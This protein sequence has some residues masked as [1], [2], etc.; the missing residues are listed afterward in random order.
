MYISL[1]ARLRNTSPISSITSISLHFCH[2]V[3]AKEDKTWVLTSN[4][5]NG[6]LKIGTGKGTRKVTVEYFGLHVR[7]HTKNG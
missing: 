3:I 6:Y 2:F 7:G 1:S 5:E 4:Q